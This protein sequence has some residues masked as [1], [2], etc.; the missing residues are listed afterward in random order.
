MSKDICLGHIRCIYNL[1]AESVSLTHS[2][3]RL[4]IAVFSS[5]SWLL[6]QVVVWAAVC[7]WQA[8]TDGLCLCVCRCPTLGSDRVEQRHGNP[9]VR[10]L[11]GCYQA[12]DF[13]EISL[14][15][16]RS[17]LKG[18]EGQRWSRLLHLC[19]KPHGERERPAQPQHEMSSQ[20][21][22]IHF[23]KTWDA[24]TQRETH[25]L[26]WIENGLIFTGTFAIVLQMVLGLEL[27][28]H[29]GGASNS[30]RVLHFCWGEVV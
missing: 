6:L 14:L 8:I 21:S 28:L 17:G 9:L 22:L 26:T 18:R 2:L 7:W 16:P 11:E 19:N 4:S 12:L 5:V 10:L 15:H 27:W 20:L 30:F 3:L 23:L 24:H 29:I 1:S 25:P 13:P